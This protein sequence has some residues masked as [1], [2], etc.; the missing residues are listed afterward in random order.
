MDGIQQ[1]VGHGIAVATG[2]KGFLFPPS[3]HGLSPE[4]P[5]LKS[6]NTR[7]IKMPY[8]TIAGDRGRGDSPNSSDGVVPYSSSHLEHAQSELI[9]P[10]PHGSY[11]LPQTI[12]ELQRILRLHLQNQG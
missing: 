4:S 12:A 3:V 2:R 6:L 8:H 9:V 11:A 1:Q 10:G 7:P 5:L